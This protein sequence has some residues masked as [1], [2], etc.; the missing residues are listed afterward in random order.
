MRSAGTVRLRIYNE[1]AELANE[2][3]EVKPAGAQTT[4]FS[5]AGFGSGVYLYVLVLDYDDG[6]HEGFPPRNFAILH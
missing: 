4:Q 5:V 6:T 3:V 2:V 1:K